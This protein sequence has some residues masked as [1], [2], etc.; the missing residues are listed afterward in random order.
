MIGKHDEQVYSV[1]FHPVEA[2]VVSGSRDK[3][4]CMW[5]IMTGKRIR[6]LSGHEDVVRSVAFNSDGTKIV[7]GSWD[8]T[9]R[10]WKTETGKCV[11]VFEKYDCKVN[12]VAL[13]EDSSLIFSAS[14]SISKDVDDKT[15]HVWRAEDKV[16][17]FSGPQ[18]D[19]KF[20]EKLGAVLKESKLRPM[21]EKF[22]F[23]N[24]EETIGL[25]GEGS[26]LRPLVYISS[27]DKNVAFIWDNKNIHFVKRILPYK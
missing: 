24:P 2:H 27:K 16:L 1:A 26:K 8:K 22:Y 20:R 3:T 7:S 15:I 13:S 21:A 11:N 10:I 19:D 4:I 14:G 5:D 17:L 12:N 6:I 9:A 23:K 18:L 25:S